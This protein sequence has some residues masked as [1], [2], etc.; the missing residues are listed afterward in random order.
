MT[1]NPFLQFASAEENPFLQFEK[2]QK[3]EA[4]LA[5]GART[6][7]QGLT[8]AT[9]DEIEAALRAAWDSA[10]GADFSEAYDN[11][12]A[13]A[14]K[15]IKD[16]GEARPVLA[17]AL[18]V[19]GSLPTMAIPGMGAAKAATLGGKALN[20]AKVGGISGAAYGFGSGEG[21]QD[22]ILNAAEGG[23]I[24]AAVAPVVATVAT[25]LVSGTVQGA[26]AA[27]RMVGNALDVSRSLQAQADE[28]IAK[29]IGRTRLPD[30]SG[31]M[32]PQDAQAYLDAGQQILK[33]RGKNAAGS[34]PETLADVGTGTLRLARAA[35]GVPGVGAD[36]AETTL[37]DRTRTQY[38][39]MVDHLKRSLGVKSSKY[40]KTESRLIDEQRKLSDAAYTAA[41][42]NAKPLD[43][44]PVLR[45]WL[46]KSFYEAGDDKK[47]LMKAMDLFWQPLRGM[48]KGQ[49]VQVLQQFDGAKRALD[50]MIDK[51]S[52]NEKRLLV[53][54]KKD[55]LKAVDDQ[56]SNPL[57]K[58]AR[59]VYSSRAELLDALRMG[60]DAFKG[61]VEA[62]AKMFVD[63]SKAEKKMFKI[64]MAQEA[65]KKMASKR[66]GEDLSL[67]FDRPAS[68]ELFKAIMTPSQ[69]KNF[70]ARYGREMNMAHTKNVVLGN[71]QTAEKLQDLA[72]LNPFQAMG[73]AIAD[74]GLV[75]AAMSKVGDWVQKAFQMREAE[76]RLIARDLFEQDPAK[77]RAILNRI[78]AQYGAAARQKLAQVVEEQTRKY[79]ASP[80]VSVTGMESGLSSPSG[81]SEPKKQAP[82]VPTAKR[83]SAFED[84]TAPKMASTGAFDDLIGAPSEVASAPG[85]FDDL[86][87]A[88]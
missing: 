83:T 28:R 63:L 22:R 7:L 56:N 37:T 33:G 73:K 11:R 60:R 26:K 6:A 27:G 49:S 69:Y 23:L 64:G 66:Y 38:L 18:E 54:L 81:R 20:A 76:A 13:H 36:I 41:Y 87:S 45:S 62:T 1:D 16:F 88:A 17:T 86:L 78:E 19:G 21:A 12:L 75:G 84:L 61:D 77:Q 85:A 70:M 80:L 4:T 25:P 31:Y 15:S 3:P 50:T 9:G 39:R 68:Q 46:A 48:K 53:M 14:R 32:T 35:K 55:L 42:A 71:S 24:G 5:G 30:G 2:A 79:I 44:E 29:A 67:M 57:Y 74:K 82:A 65:Q 40:D 47:T 59:E 58:D 10:N 43:I 72:D 51:S 34:L 8:A 52:S